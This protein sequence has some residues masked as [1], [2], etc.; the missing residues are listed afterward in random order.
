MDPESHPGVDD[1]LPDGALPIASI[2]GVIY[3]DPGGTERFSWQ[4]GQNSSLATTCGL[5]NIIA[6]ALL[7]EGRAPIEHE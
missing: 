7:T 2:R 3:L 4:S 6:H 5:V 1:L